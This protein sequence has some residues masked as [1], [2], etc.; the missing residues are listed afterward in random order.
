MAIL[1][2]TSQNLVIFI[3]NNRRNTCPAPVQITYK[4]KVKVML[5]LCLI[6]HYAMKIYGGVEI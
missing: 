1:G 4:L 5:A 6:K 2:I 3:T